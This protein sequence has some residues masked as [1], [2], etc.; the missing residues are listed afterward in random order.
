MIDIPAYGLFDGL[1]DGLEYVPTDEPTYEP[2]DGLT[3]GNKL[4]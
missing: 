3:Y 4:E 2:N 1:P